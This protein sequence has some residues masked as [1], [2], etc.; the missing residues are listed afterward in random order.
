MKIERSF[1]FHRKE[2]KR[3]DVVL[4][5]WQGY[6]MGCDCILTGDLASVP[7]QFGLR[8]IEFIHGLNRSMRTLGASD[9]TTAYVSSGVENLVVALREGLDRFRVFA[10]FPL[11]NN[12]NG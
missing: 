11:L 2:V 10:T 5:R 9:P 12:G 7:D 6:Q 8:L 4:R 3:V 1:T